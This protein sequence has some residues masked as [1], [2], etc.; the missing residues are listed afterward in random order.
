MSLTK[1]GWKTGET[2]GQ[3]TET[4]VDINAFLNGQD[5]GFTNLC[6]DRFAAASGKGDSGSPVFS[7]SSATLP[8]N[9]TIPAYLY[10]ILWGGNGSSSSFSAMANLEA[11]VGALKTANGQAGANSPPEVRILQPTTNITV[12]SGG[13]NGV[14]FQASVVDY[15]G[16]C[17]QVRWDSSLDGLI[18]MGTSFN[19]VFSS[20]GT[21][22]ITVTAKDNNGSVATNTVVVAVQNDKPTVWIIS[23]TQAQKLYTGSPYVFEGSS[24]DSNEP[25]QKL[26]CSAMKWTSNI[27]ADPFP[28][29]GCTP[30][31]TFSTP[32]LRTITLK[33]TD[34]NGAFDTDSVQI[35]V[36]APPV[37]GPPTVTILMPAGNNTG[38]DA[39]TWVK[40]QGTANDPDNESPLTYKWW[41]KN[42]S[43]WTLLFTGS[44]NDAAIVSKWWKPATNV[45]FHCGGTPVRLYLYATDPD[46]M[47]G[48]DYVDVYI[49]YPTC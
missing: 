41:L 37:N 20:P 7:W 10:G 11:T 35:N 21:R 31:V 39:N 38:F 6:Q 40:L 1:V 30:A 46:G 24:W 2:S 43:V 36:A 12:G 4:C 47:T 14:D 42:G 16:C 32:G 34:S 23:P 44:M 28:V 49:F 48:S 29:S 33:G 27:G 22:T 26:S 25:F 18:G 17:A 15:E 9:A 5:T 19:Y 8:P 3:V 45:P 13:L